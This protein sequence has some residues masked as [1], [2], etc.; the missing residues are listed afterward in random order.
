MGGGYAKSIQDTVEIQLETE[1]IAA[2]RGAAFRLML[3]LRL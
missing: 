2:E 3:P 1:R